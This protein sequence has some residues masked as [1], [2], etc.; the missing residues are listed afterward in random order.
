M[1]GLDAPL[2]AVIWQH[3]LA[4]P[5]E[6]HWTSA[7]ALFCAV[8]SIYLLDRLMDAHAMRQFPEEVLPTRHRFSRRHAALLR[9]LLGAVIL[10]GVY[11]V[12]HLETN[13]V[14]AGIGLGLCAGLYL[15]GNQFLPE[16]P[17]KHWSKE[18]VIAIIF[19]MGCALVSMV[20]EASWSLAVAT[21]GLGVIAWINCSQ[22]AVFESE[23]DRLAGRT[24]PGFSAA[25]RARGLDFLI[26]LTVTIALFGG[27]CLGNM[28]L[29]GV[30]L[31]AALLGLSHWWNRRFGSE[32]GGA[33]ADAA[34]AAP[35]LLMVISTG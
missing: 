30:A 18:V 13:L 9:W 33:W 8:W 25:V 4:Y 22:I 6:P 27:L 17:A 11:A 26:P 12:Q 1:T 15:I 28:A 20:A 24:S 31:S 10:A 23:F 16:C 35:V 34:L 7:A 29:V 21:I 19:A 2:I 3:L 14:L 5:R 32:A